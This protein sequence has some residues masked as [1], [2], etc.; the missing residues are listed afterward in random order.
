MGKKTV[1]GDGDFTTFYGANFTP[2]HFG[3]GAIPLC[4]ARLRKGLCI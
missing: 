3:A 1:A 2:N 4:Y